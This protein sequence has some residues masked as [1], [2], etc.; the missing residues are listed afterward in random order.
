MYH[1]ENCGYNIVLTNPLTMSQ[2]SSSSY[3]DYWQSSNEHDG[4]S[5]YG[6]RDV[7][8]YGHAP[9]NPRWPKNAKV[10]KHVHSGAAIMSYPARRQGAVIFYTFQTPFDLVAFG[11]FWSFFFSSS[12]DPTTIIVIVAT[13]KS[14]M[15]MMIANGHTHSLTHSHCFMYHH[16]VG[17]SLSLSRHLLH[18]PHKPK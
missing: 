1:D 4:Q 11:F 5:K 9:P 16:L 6:G 13:K 10:S 12:L 15:M 17:P 2:P 18:D 14:I 7:V 8:G 3:K